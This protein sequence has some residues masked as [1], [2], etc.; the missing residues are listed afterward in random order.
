MYKMLQVLLPLLTAVASC[1][2]NTSRGNQETYNLQDTINAGTDF[3]KSIAPF[4][5]LE[6][7]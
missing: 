1:Y 6:F 4:N 3:F 7:I 5:L 2:L